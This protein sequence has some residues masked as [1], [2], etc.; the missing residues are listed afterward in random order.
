MPDHDPLEERGQ[1]REQDGGRV[2]LDQ[3]QVGPVLAE[4]GAQTAQ[5]ALRDVVQVLALAHDAQVPVDGQ[6]EDL[7]RLV[8]QVG[9]LAGERDAGFDRVR[10]RLERA[11]D[12][13]E[14]DALRARAHHHQDP[15][16]FGHSAA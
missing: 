12:G 16:T 4:D 15:G 9:V 13:R 14:L 5:T 7:E 3:D 10:V 1:G 6:I 11:H 8:E 2:A